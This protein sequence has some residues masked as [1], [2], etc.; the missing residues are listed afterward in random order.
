MA[1]FN[2]KLLR[3]G[4]EIQRVKIKRVPV[5]VFVDQN[6]RWVLANDCDYWLKSHPDV[7]ML[8]LELM[9]LDE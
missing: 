2:N 6:S 9:F 3:N 7:Q 4:Q 1:M 5:N 8:K